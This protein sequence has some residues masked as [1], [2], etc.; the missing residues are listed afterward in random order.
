MSGELAEADRLR[1]DG[2]L[3]GAA[4]AVARQIQASA[5]D[6]ELAAA[7][8]AL[9]EGRL[10]EA[11]GLARAALERRPDD[12]AAL[13]LFAE[14]AARAGRD[15]DAEAL[16][17]RALAIAPGFTAARF[18]YALALHQQGKTAQTIAEAERLLR[19][20]PGHPLYLQLGAA[21]RMRV[22]DYAASAD[23]YRAVLDAHPELALTWMAYGH[24]LKT[25]G[26]QAEAVGAYRQ[27]VKLRPALGE[28]W[29]SLANLKTVALSADDAA[30]MAAE[31]ARGD[32]PDEDRFHLQF[33][34]GKAMEDDGRDADA[35]GLYAQANA[36]RRKSQPYD[37]WELAGHVA[38]CKALFAP[39]FFAARA[40]CGSPAPDPIFIVGLPRSGSTLIEQILASHS[41]VEG[42]QELPDLDA[43]AWRL[44]GAAARP[45]EG[46]Y[47]DILAAL[48]PAEFAALGAEY[49]A[50]ARPHRK[51][52]SP[53]FIDKLPNNFAHVALIQLILPNAK[54]IDARRHPVAC[55]FSA[56][57]QHF[58]VG[59]AFTYDLADLASY[60]RDYAELMAHFDAVLPGRV[61]RVIYERLVADPEAQVRRLLAY[62][63][64]PFE[65]GC[66]R[67][68]ENER[69][70][71]TASS[72]Q[73]RR[74]IFT[75]GL[76]HWRR[77]E[78]WLG[79]LID[80]LGNL[81]TA[82]PDS[83]EMRQ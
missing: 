53:F 47:P 61:H 14:V 10:A 79:P 16:L 78:P 66:L 33:A 55:G 80:G 62:C 52:G 82:Y 8:Q 40:G 37:P 70:V 76:D 73:V 6:P 64:L 51:E 20:T 13:R 42:T 34:L 69:A 77:F 65:A 48:S 4:L 38:R 39:S 9:V 11:H 49:L 72:E 27:A 41:Q 35:F 71:R 28:A 54:I 26:R 17:A 60:Y 25:L 3:A 19:E 18:A 45:S 63:G 75:E 12:P 57:R 22:G 30:A 83:P 58:A 31:L 36:L 21:A 5:P 15:N 29:W 23:A 67:F 50:R 32:L 7:A 43:I 24:A 68:Y 46:A 2:D 81:V 56:F 1:L 74:P 59:Q 44:G